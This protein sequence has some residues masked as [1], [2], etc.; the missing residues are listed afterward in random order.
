MTEQA[1][2]P[3]SEFSNLVTCIALSPSVD[4]FSPSSLP[5]LQKLTCH[6]YCI[7]CPPAHPLPISF[8]R[9]KGTWCCS[10]TT[11]TSYPGSC[12]LLRTRPSYFL[13]SLGSGTVRSRKLSFVLS[14]S[15]ATLKLLLRGIQLSWSW[16]TE[17][18]PPTSALIP[19]LAS[20]FASRTLFNIHSSASPWAR[21]L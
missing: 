12:E 5:P 13:S 20:Q 16:I 18:H 11:N 10:S 21:D 7:A 19:Y 1:F 9:S 8:S 15:L 6:V 14:K 2:T 4:S 3:K 17:V